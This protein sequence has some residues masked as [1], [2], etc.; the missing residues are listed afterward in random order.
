MPIKKAL[1]VHGGAGNY[2]KEVNPERAK[3]ILR[4]LTESLKAGQEILSKKGNAIDAVEAAVKFLEDHPLFNAG[5]GSVFTHE[6]KIEMDASIM[7]GK[8]LSAGS[9]AFITNIKNPVTAARAVM[10]KSQHVLL[11]GPGAEIFAREMKLEMEDPTYF[12]T[13]HRYEQWKELKE[14]NRSELNLGTVGAV[15]LDGSGNLAAATSTGGM[16]NKKFGR[17]GDSPIIGAGVYA[18]N[19]TCAV[20]STGHGEYFIRLNSAYDLSAMMEYQNLSLEDAAH[21]VIQKLI[22]NGGSGGI[23]A[24]DRA[25]N[26]SM[27]FS[28]ETMFRGF[29]HE[30]GIPHSFIF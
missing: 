2:K 15:A 14:T 3:E 18:N 13:Q 27:P 17:I 10:E 20:S 8:D 7:N 23:I 9:V 16:T 22:R 26:I 24:V 12:F 29:I 11:V 5:K 4:A 19:N 1:A 28:T 21:A 6:G 30:D 25:G